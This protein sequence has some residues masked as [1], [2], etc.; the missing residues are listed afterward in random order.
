M[1]SRTVALVVG[2][3]VVAVVVQTTLF[4]RLRLITPDLV[5]LLC[6]MLAM[7]RMRS[8]AVLAASFLSGLMVDLLGSSLLGLRAIVFA[9]VAFI[10]LRTADRADIGRAIMAVWAGGLTM[11]GVLLIIVIG[12]VFGEASLLGAGAGSRLI[13]V[14]V[15]NLILAALFAP[16]FVRLV[17]RDR[18]AFRYL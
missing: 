15:A 10:A 4:G 9:A 13:W 7:T 1:R 6:I 3:I 2:S 16:L 17:D 8:E 18:T 12:T 11:M 14:P 5:M